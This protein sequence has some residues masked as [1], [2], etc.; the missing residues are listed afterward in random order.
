MTYVGGDGQVNVKL[1]VVDPGR[2]PVRIECGR[3]CALA[4]VE[5]TA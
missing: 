1:A 3:E 2:R 4:E 5:F